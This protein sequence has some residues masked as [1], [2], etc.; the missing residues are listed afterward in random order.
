[1]MKRVFIKQIFPEGTDM[2]KIRKATVCIPEMLIHP[3]I[4]S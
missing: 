3:Q 2:S 1:M 4:I